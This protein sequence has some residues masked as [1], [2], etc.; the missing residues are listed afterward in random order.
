MSAISVPPLV[1]FRLR[2]NSATSI[3]RWGKD[4]A[5]MKVFEIVD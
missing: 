5:W 1:H 2:F 3:Q 4:L